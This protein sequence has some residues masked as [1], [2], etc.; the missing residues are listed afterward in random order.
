[1]KHRDFLNHVRSLTE[2]DISGKITE[3]RKKLANLE[4]D[5]ILGKLKNFHEIKSLRLEIA[6][7]NTILDEKLVASLNEKNN[8]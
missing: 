6:R 1:M 3:S 2:G 4:Q 5:K 8:G 7:Y